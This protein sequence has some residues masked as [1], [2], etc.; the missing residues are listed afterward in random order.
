MGESERKGSQSSAEAEG[1]CF[2][3]LQDKNSIFVDF[4]II[5]IIL[6]F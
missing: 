5:I 6:I 4:F 2:S 3:Q 1:D